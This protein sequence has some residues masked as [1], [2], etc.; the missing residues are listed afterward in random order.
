MLEA[1]KKMWV[2]RRARRILLASLLGSIGWTTAFAQSSTTTIRPPFPTT[3]DEITVSI[4]EGFVMPGYGAV[5]KAGSVI[6]V[7]FFLVGCGPVLPPW[8]SSTL[9]LGRLPAG[10]YRIVTSVQYA[11]GSDSG[12]VVMGNGPHPRGELG[13]SVS[14]SLADPNYSDL[15]WNPL[16]SGWGLGVTHH[17]SG[18][19]FAVWYTYESD[20][21]PTW[22]VLPG[23]AWVDRTTFSGTIYRTSG[24]PF[25]GNFDPAAVT[26]VAAGQGTLAFSTR[27]SGTFT[28]TIDGV[29]G[30][31]S[32]VRQPF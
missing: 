5:T 3:A 20:G 28:Y 2:W 25:A 4:E 23:G 6:T 11:C 16:E 12:G 8:T 27:D 18:Q 30:S 9:S 32:I 1:R 26:R 7:N 22:Y 29:Q 15:W 13:V 14:A 24:P 19:V 10:T 31:K 17:E 21:K